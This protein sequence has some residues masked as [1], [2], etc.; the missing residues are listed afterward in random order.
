VALTIKAYTL[1]A[2]LYFE[3]AKRPGQAAKLLLARLVISEAAKLLGRPGLKGRSCRTPDRPKRVDRAVARYF[4]QV[5]LVALAQRRLVSAMKQFERALGCDGRDLDAHL[6]RAALALSFRGYWIAH[7]S[8]TAVLKQRPRHV[9]ALVGL[10]VACRGLASAPPEPGRPKKTAA[11][12][13]QQAATHY[14]R[15]LAIDSGAGEAAFNLGRLY[16][17]HLNDRIQGGD[18]FARYLRLPARRTSASGRKEAR[19][20]LAEIAYQDRIYCRMKPRSADR[21]TCLTQAR[22][23]WQRWGLRAR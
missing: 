22:A 12:W 13:Y 23:R 19:E 3:R 14:R 7:D 9:D 15:A 16:L 11:H 18:W 4:N 21:A 1:L 17:D 5:G 6:N 10:G 2:Q 8:F 20:Q